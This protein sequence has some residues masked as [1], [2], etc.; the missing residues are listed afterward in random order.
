MDKN[1]LL[2]MVIALCEEDNNGGICA[3]CHETVYGVEPDAEGYECDSCGSMAVYGAEQ[4]LLSFVS[5]RTLQY[6]NYAV[7]SVPGKSR[8]IQ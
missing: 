5:T 2:D 1:E 3:E 8:N 6:R 7:Y 4:Y